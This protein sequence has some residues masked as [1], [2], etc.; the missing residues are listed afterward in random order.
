MSDSVKPSP[1]VSGDA[2]VVAPSPSGEGVG[3]G[4]VIRDGG[5]E[6]QP[7]PAATRITDCP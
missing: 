3:G 6:T 7:R 4:G 5:F 2:P 1:S